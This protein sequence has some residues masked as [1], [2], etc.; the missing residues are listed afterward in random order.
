[1]RGTTK[2]LGPA[3]GAFVFAPALFVTV[4]IERGGD[5][6]DELHIHA[7]GQGLW[8]ARMLARLGI[9]VVLCGPFGGETG[10]V[11]RTLVAQEGIQ[12]SAVEV[13]AWTGGYVDD[14]REGGRTK[15]AEV[16]PQPLSRHELDE[17][18]GTAI[19][20]ALEVPVSVLGG[21]HQPSP[22]PPDVYRRLANDIGSA[23][24][25]VVAD[26]SGATLDAALA[27]GVDVLKVSHEDLVRDGHA[28][29]S[30]LDELA[31]SARELQ[32]RGATHV[33]V[34]RAAE[35]A[36]LLAGDE[37]YEIVAPTLEPADSGGAGDSMTAGIAAGLVERLE[38][39]DAVRLGAAAGTLNATRHGRG[40]G[41]D[42]QIK[43][44]AS[45]IVAR[46]LV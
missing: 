1:M 37:I 33:V 31:A 16:P 13:G 46:P 34:S 35:P 19:V 29:S 17:L 36:L 22:V 43:Q 44:F 2:D 15:V 12:V 42:S 28:R 8:I 3:S 20:A 4:T 27:G 10:V 39:I 30:A 11:A 18:Y 9:D 38:I 25:S 21:P 40:S 26:L 14:R 7:G 6:A 23:D 32:R 5:D 41:D 45:Q 24:R